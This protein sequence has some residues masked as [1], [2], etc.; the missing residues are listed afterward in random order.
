MYFGLGNVE[1]RTASE[2]EA[3]E[4]VYK[5]GQKIVLGGGAGEYDYGD[6]EE[7]VYS[8][9]EEEEEPEPEETEEERLRREFHW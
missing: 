5:P 7:E 9:E 2:K 6:D 4:K 1:E 8:D 3:L